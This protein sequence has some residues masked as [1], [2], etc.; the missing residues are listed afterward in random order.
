M[1]KILPVLVVLALFPVAE[2]R[3]DS[4]VVGDYVQILS[5]PN[6]VVGFPGGEFAVLDN[7]NLFITFCLEYAEHI[8]TGSFYWVGGIGSA[9][10]NGGPVNAASGATGTSDPIDPMTAYLF[11]QFRSGTYS[12]FSDFAGG[13]AAA[14][15]ELQMAIWHIEGEYS[16]ADPMSNIFY[17]DALAAL[18]G[19]SPY[20][21][22]TWM[23]LGNVAALNLYTTRTEVSPGV[24]VYTGFA[25]DQLVMASV[26]EP[27]T[28]VLLGTG[29]IG[30]ALFVRRRGR[31]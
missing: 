10:V 31:K 18:A 28:L 15:R 11:T 8:S 29:L 6:R 14:A 22:G 5:G 4:I 20:F 12:V 16:L 27:G 21:S 2:A 26:P 7:G 13:L 19:T 17:R 30:L 23:G 25:Q 3:A 9:A 1:R 24:F